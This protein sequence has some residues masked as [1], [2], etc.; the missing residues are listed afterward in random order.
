MVTFISLLLGI[1]NIVIFTYLIIEVSKKW[2]YSKAHKRFSL[3]LPIITDRNVL[4]FIALGDRNKAYSVQD[5]EYLEK[6][7][8]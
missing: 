4:G 1:L 6:L 3:T 8:E 7:S 2:R 5:V